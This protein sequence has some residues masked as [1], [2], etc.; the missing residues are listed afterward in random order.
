MINYKAK[1]L[2]RKAIANIAKSFRKRMNLDGECY[3]PILEFIENVL[4]Q[5][6]PNFDY[7]IVDYSELSVGTYALTYP[8]SSK[9]IIRKDVYDA[10]CANQGR[11][12]FTLAHELWH[13]LGHESENISFARSTEKVP[14]YMDPEWQANTF[15]AELLIPNYLVNGM[16]VDE[17]MNKCGV[18]RQ[19]AEIQMRQYGLL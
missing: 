3:F 19:C 5:I 16:T 14:A 8:D 10:A 6:D 7:E 13:Y 2:S 18:S 9:M 11:A 4:P 1:P 15:A 17:I 12:R